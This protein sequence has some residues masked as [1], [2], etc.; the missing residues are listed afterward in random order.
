MSE[1]ES[2]FWNGV[3]DR[4]EHYADSVDRQAAAA[5]EVLLD[6][7]AVGRGSAV[8][9]LGCGPG[10]AGLAAARRTGATGRVMFADVAPAML[11]VVSRRCQGL[12]G[13]ST[14]TANLRTI[15]APDGSFDA[16]VCRYALMFAEDP[17]A[18]IGEA[19]RVLRP[20]GRYT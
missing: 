15:A 3:A 14:M 2:Q 10:G 6:A 7:A 9:D 5:T 11:D 19:V 18:A 17:V 20:G 4:W 16:V 12:P 8:L 13:T 1:A